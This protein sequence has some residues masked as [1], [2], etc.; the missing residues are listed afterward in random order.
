M[1]DQ[2]FDC[3]DKPLELTFIK[4]FREYNNKNYVCIIGILM[5]GGEAVGEIYWHPA[6]KDYVLRTMEGYCFTKETVIKATAFL[7][8]KKFNHVRKT[9]TKYIKSRRFKKEPVGTTIALKL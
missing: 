6:N 8:K 5:R 7:D 9:L 4:C 2:E 1:S 3:T